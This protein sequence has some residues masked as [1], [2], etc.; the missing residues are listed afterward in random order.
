MSV[1]RVERKCNV[2]QCEL[3]VGSLYCS[4]TS[5]KLT[6][7]ASTPAK[8]CT[9]ERNFIPPSHTQSQPLKLAVAPANLQRHGQEYLEQAHGE[10]PVGRNRIAGQALAQPLQ[11]LRC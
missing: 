5:S 10:R 2:V 8:G 11:R 4:L 6:G 9:S 3:Y 7:K 1:Q